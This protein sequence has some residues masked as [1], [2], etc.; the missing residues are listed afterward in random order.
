[1]VYSN[2][3]VSTLKSMAKRN[4]QIFFLQNYVQNRYHSNLSTTEQY[5][6]PHPVPLL[7]NNFIDE[8]CVIIIP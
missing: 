1:M 7:I 4:K 2:Q 3:L 8:L 5:F 6:L